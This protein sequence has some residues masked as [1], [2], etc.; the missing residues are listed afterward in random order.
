MVENFRG[1]IAYIARHGQTDWNKEKRFQGHFDIPL[2]EI[3]KKQ[4]RA[5]ALSL[6]DKGITAIYSSPK[7]RAV[8][9]AETVGK[10][11]GCGVEIIQDL[12]EITHGVFD[13]MT[14]DEVYARND[15]AIT[16][17]R[18]DRVNVAPPEGESIRQ[19]YERVV[20][21]FEELVQ[22]NKSGTFLLVSHLVVTK[23]LLV[24]CLDAPLE[25]FWRFDQG[26]TAL[27]KIRFNDSGPVVELMNYTGHLDGLKD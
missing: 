23:A 21:A 6:V 10:A 25:V 8:E 18:E 17:W 13:G 26:S 1:T 12:R 15:E 9:T 7:G 4:A 20:P 27:N 22:R 24:K 19:C 3:G 5:L 11:V 2:N 14:L 16:R